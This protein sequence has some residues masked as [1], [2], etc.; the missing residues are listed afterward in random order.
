MATNWYPIIKGNCSKCEKCIEFCPIDNMHIV[1]KQLLIK[2]GFQCP[3]ECK[4]C[5]ENCKYNAVSY[6]DGTEESIM[7]AF[8]GECHCHD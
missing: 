4:V 1:N 5:K 7:N 8:G 3:S 6:Y 2:D